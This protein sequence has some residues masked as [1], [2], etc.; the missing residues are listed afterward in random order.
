MSDLANGLERQAYEQL[1]KARQYPAESSLRK[2]N[3]KHVKELL[4]QAKRL[5]L[6][7][8]CCGGHA[9]YAQHLKTATK[10]SS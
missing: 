6:A 5:R 2:L 10:K 7:A 3:E 8:S 1:R 4:Q 9:N